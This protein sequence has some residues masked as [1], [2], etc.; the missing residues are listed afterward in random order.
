MSKQNENPIL[1]LIVQC[2][3]VVIIVIFIKGVFELGK[4]RSEFNASVKESDT[5]REHWKE[6]QRRQLNKL[7]ESLR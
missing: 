1:K 6:S 2:L 7:I 3:A 5:L 4:Y